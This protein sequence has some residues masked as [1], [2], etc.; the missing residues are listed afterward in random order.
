MA[1]GDCVPRS[2]QERFQAL[3]GIPVREAYGMTE[4]GP[5]AVNPANAIRS[6]S[7]GKPFDGVEVRIVDS[8]GKDVPD[9]KTGEIA[10]RSPANFAGHWDGPAETSEVLRDSWLHIGDL[11]GRAADGYL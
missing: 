3:F 6:G 7:L 9:G 8:D 2:T 11:A 5:S 10:V 1:G 4:T